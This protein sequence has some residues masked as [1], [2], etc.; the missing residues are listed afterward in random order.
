[1]CQSLVGS[2]SVASACGL[3]VAFAKSV[4][5]DMCGAARLVLLLL[6]HQLGVAAAVGVRGRQP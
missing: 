4:P 1:M 6:L 3:E 5:S 2:S